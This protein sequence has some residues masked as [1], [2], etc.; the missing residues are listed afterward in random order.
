LVNERI[1][2]LMKRFLRAFFLAALL[3]VPFVA[4]RPAKAQ[5][6][7]WIQVEAQPSL[8][9]AR[10]RTRSYAGRFEDVNGFS[11]G[12]GWY[13][14]ALGPFTPED[15]AARL[16]QLKDQ[17]LIP[18]DSFVADGA[19]FRQQFWP[20]GANGRATPAA[21]ATALPQIQAQT[22][23]QTQPTLAAT[24]AP[25]ADETPRQA[26]ASEALL[27]REERQELQTALQWE[28]YYNSAIDGAF[29][30]GT[31]AAM[32]DW[33]TAQGQ[34]ATGIL[35]SAQ[36]R[37]LLGAYRAVLASIGMKTVRDAAAGIEIAMPTALVGFTKYEFPFAHYD[38]KPGSRMRVL[39]ISEYGDQGTLLGL[40]DIMQTLEIVPPEG[41]RRRKKSSFEI[42]GSNDSITSYTYATLTDGAV[43]GFTLVW[44]TGDEKRRTRVLQEMRASFASTGDTA[45]DETT[46]APDEE[47]RIDLVAGLQIRKPALSRSGFYVDATGTVLTT[48]EAVQG[49]TRITL[50]GE[51]DADLVLDD[52]AAGLAILHAKAP[53][54]PP[55]YA[56]FRSATPR[57]KSEIAVAGYSY[58]GALDAPTLTFGKLADIRGLKGEDTL[59]RLT[60]E[61]EPGDAGGP[62]LDA[63]GLVQGMLLPRASDGKRLPGDVNFALNANTLMT[64][65][66]ESGVTVRD[67]DPTGAVAPEDLTTKAEAMTVLVSC[68]K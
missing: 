51:Y 43:K 5:I 30:R 52:A 53:L 58:Q 14:I 20:V 19:N 3:L 46:D 23:A 42:T 27:S 38:G 45:L 60:L 33:Q 56:T 29:G 55:A 8:R 65:A 54:T 4:D 37:E 17:G 18:G 10:T 63:A 44:P 2:N 32:A 28:G 11:L 12:G 39:L 40:Y 6:V 48:S 7:E 36:R 57:L 68:W 26:R 9:E 13:A 24:P 22:Q 67:S 35:T 64:L 21:V 15:A 25:V 47:Q 66:A 59:Q 16:Q 31:R 61:V 49:C 34:E 50:D 62:V 41:P 1:E